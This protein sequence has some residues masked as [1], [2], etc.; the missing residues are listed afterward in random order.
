MRASRTYWICLVVAASCTTLAVGCSEASSAT[1]DA[2]A[3]A[4]A[5]GDADGDASADSTSPQP[6]ADGSTEDPEDASPDAPGGPSVRIDGKCYAICQT[7]SD[8]DGDGWGSENGAACVMPA[9]SLATSSPWCETPVPQTSYEAPS[10]SVSDETTSVAV[11]PRPPKLAL[12]PPHNCPHSASGLT[13]WNP[14]WLGSDGVVAIP[15]QT[16]VLVHGNDDIPAGTLLRQLTIPASSELIFADQAATFRVTDIEVAGAMRLGSPTCRLQS[17]IRFEFDTDEDVSSAGVRSAI[18]DRM[19]LGIMVDSMGVLDVFGTRHQPTWTRL[20]ATAN[21]GTRQLVLAESVDWQPGQKLIVATSDRYDYP[22]RDQ[23]EVRTITSINGGTTVTIDAPLAYRH[24]GGPEYQVEVGL[25]SHNIRFATADRILQAAPTFGGHIMVHSKT[26]RIS[27]AELY[28]LGQQNF[29]GRYPIHFHLSGDVTG[30]SYVTDSSIWRSNWRCAVLHRTDHALISRN[31]AYDVFGHCYYLEDGVEM[32]NELSYNL[33]VKPKIL[34]PIDQASIDALNGPPQTGFTLRQSSEYAQPADRAAAGFYI[35][36]GNNRIIGNAASGGFAGFSFPN[37]PKAI[38]G[39][40]ERIDPILY[41]VSHFDGNTAHSAGYF[42]GDTGCVY[43]GGTLREVDDGGQKVLEYTSGRQTDPNLLRRT[44]EVFNN[45]KT[46]L[47]EAG[48]THWGNSPRAVNLESWDN[49]FLAKLFG[50]ASIHGGLSVGRTGNTAN[51]SSRPRSYYQRGFQFYDTRT[52]T[53]LRNVVFRN[54]QHDPNSGSLSEHDSC[55]LLGMTHSD[56]FTPQQMNATSGL[57]FVNVSEGQRIC[58][59]NSGTLASRNFNLIDNDGSA[60]FINGD[61][62]PAGPRLVG[63]GYSD[64]WRTSS[65]CVHHDAWGLWICPLDAPHAV[66]SVGTVPNAN[67]QVQ[68]YGIDNTCRGTNHY[69]AVEY[70]DAQIT[71]PSGTGWHHV[72]PGGVPPT[73]DVQTLQVPANSFVVLSFTLPPSVTC[74]VA[75]WSASSSLTSL[76]AS[77]GATY[78]TAQNTCFIRIP[79]TNLGSFTASGLSVA[80][81]TWRGNPSPTTYFT[82]N[83]GCAPSN[84]A[85]QSVVSIIPT[86]P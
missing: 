34:G 41:G 8:P 17:D 7:S 33:A 73:F 52:Q 46:F 24:Y 30:T 27:G 15:P 45:T 63:S 86:M 64:A 76:L 71:A 58:L 48:I 77:T 31:V 38:G 18:Y 22:I 56:Q 60:T 59:G 69:S 44:P 32:N 75:G 11:I 23:N 72:F 9:S 65:A 10:L 61:G 47:C 42:W 81:M 53:I 70:I 4:G 84:A 50:A 29:I 74:S 1:E 3:D 5:N 67:V 37:L 20:A 55:A 68:L 39:S 2:T 12:D 51:Q 78:T 57:H 40:A 26:A 80:N 16:R 19:G 54:Y 6:S 62:L 35:S 25:L 82:V 36:N 13:T 14:S 49:G 28:G 43:A 79:P 21:A 83:T 66:A 85:C